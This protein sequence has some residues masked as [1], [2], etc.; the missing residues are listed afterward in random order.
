MTSA[1]RREE[2]NG[3]HYRSSR[4]STVNGQFFFATREG[5]LE[6]P[7]SSRPEAEYAITGYIER[8]Q[9]AEKLRQHGTQY[10]DGKFR[11]H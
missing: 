3:S 7:Y 1:N 8:M 9:L 10:L 11:S 2:P 5:T 4:L 6:G